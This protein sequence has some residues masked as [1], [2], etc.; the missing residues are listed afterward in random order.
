MISIV[1]CSFV[2]P[3]AFP[4]FLGLTIIGNTAVYQFCDC[5]VMRS[6]T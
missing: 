5:E 6:D 3:G 1:D 4:P 2:V